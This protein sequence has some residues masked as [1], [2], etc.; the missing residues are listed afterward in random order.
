MQVHVTDDRARSPARATASRRRARWPRPATSSGS[1]AMAS[2]PLVAPPGLARAIAIDLDAE[3]VRIVQVKRLADQ[4]IGHARQRPLLIGQPPQRRARAP[5]ATARGW[6]SETGRS[7]RRGLGTASRR[8]CSSIRTGPPPADRKCGARLARFLEAKH[9]AVE[10]HRAIEIRDRQA[11]RTD[12]GV[13]R[14]GRRFAIARW[15]QEKGPR[16]QEAP[17]KTAPKSGLRSRPP[18]RR[19]RCAGSGS[20]PAR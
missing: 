6:R 5:R 14:Q 20:A 7:L 8:S 19:G 11:D 18:G 2:S 15:S 1:V 10:G 12:V 3:A 13:G 9:V 17:P 4:V 16:R